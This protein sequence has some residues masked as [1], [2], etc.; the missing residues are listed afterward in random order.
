MTL[1]GD[2]TAYVA[3]SKDGLHYGSLVEWTFDDGSWLGSYNTQQHWISHSS[4][5][6][7]V[8]TRMGADNDQVFR[9]R[10]P[11][12]MAK[13]DVGKLCV[14]KET[15]CVLL[16]IPSENG[17]LGNFGVTQIGPDETWV[18]ASSLPQRGRASNIQIAKIY[19]KH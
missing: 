7:L 16:P 19:W 5:L 12:F 17:D 8:Y 3:T 18:T 11:L 2:K 1:R 15:E 10:A 14:L 4:G 9:H 6:Y 13:V